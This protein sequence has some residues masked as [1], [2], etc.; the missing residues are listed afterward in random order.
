[1]HTDAKR[2]EQI[3][4]NL[5]SNAFKFTEKGKVS[6]Q[7]A[8]A[9]QGW[10]PDNETLAHAKSVLAFSVSDTGIGVAPDKQQIIFEAFQQADGSTSRKYGGTGLGLAITREN[11]RLLG[12]E[13]RLVS[14]PG[15]G[16]TFTLYLPQT[17]V[18]AK[19]ARSP[20]VTPTTQGA[21]IISSDMGLAASEPEPS[22]LPVSQPGDDTESIL[23]GD[24]VLMIVENDA[25]SARLLLDKAHES[26]WKGLI[27]TRG[28][29]ALALARQRRPDAITLDMNL[30][31][32][33][34]WRVLASLKDDPATRHIPVHLITTDEERERGLRMGAIGAL[35]KPLES[36]E[37]LQEAFSRIKTFI[38][39]RTRNLLVVNHDETTRKK[40]L[41][42]LAEDAVHINA[43]GTGKEALAA[44]KDAHFEAAVLELDLPDMN[45]FELIEQIS[46]DASLRELPLIV[47][48]TKELS[49]KDAARLK[50]LGQTLNLREVRS[51]GRLLDHVLLFLHCEVTKLPEFKRQILQRLH[52]KDT[53]LTARKVLIVDDDIRNIFAVTSLLERYQ[54]QILSAENGKTAL[55][56]LRANPDIDVVLMD[57]MMPEMD[58]YD[59][60]RAIRKLAK[61]RTLP[62]IALT[63]RAMNGDREKCVDAGASDYIAK[64]VNSVELLA[65]LRLWLYR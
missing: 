4:K 56:L 35:T 8:P 63:S 27:A 58:G 57:I 5:L 46:K 20:A 42:L 33:D 1:M 44:L 11:A 22:A 12:G 64:P 18:P 9:N 31:D 16:S 38:E 32:L 21:L 29:D 2:L 59:T 47:Y 6:L 43:F 60:I 23:P 48:V 52:E 30:S 45:G 15:A 65:R 26:G 14:A 50:R 17:F 61:F 7:V 19:P 25:E 55:E 40:I 41:E 37:A 36:K 51:T 53:A 24:R 34:G 49:R 39:P 62:I 54:M 10:S 28:G 3:L 13:I